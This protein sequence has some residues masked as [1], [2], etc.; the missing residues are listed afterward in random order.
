[1]WKHYRMRLFHVIW[2]VTLIPRSFSTST[3]GNTLHVLR[4]IHML[5]LFSKKSKFMHGINIKDVISYTLK[6]P[7]FQALFHSHAYA[8]C[9]GHMVIILFSLLSLFWRNGSRCMRSPCCLCVCIPL[10]AF[11]CL[12]QSMWNLVCIWWHLSPSERPTP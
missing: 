7:V 1:M 3:S 11:E 12:H 5:K 6:N 8:E 10:T 9:H 4:H 2:F